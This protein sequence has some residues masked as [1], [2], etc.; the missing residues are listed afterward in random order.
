MVES[1]EKKKKIEK[2]SKERIYEMPLPNDY[3]RICGAQHFSV[4]E[5]ED[6]KKNN[7]DTIPYSVGNLERKCVQKKEF[8]VEKKKDLVKSLGEYVSSSKDEINFIQSILEPM[9]ISIN[10]KDDFEDKLAKAVFV[11]ALESFIDNLIND[12]LS[13]FQSQKKDENEIK[14][15]VP[16]HIYTSIMTIKEYMFLRKDE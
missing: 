3:C 2:K 9:K 14:V 7:W 10:H 16:I 11:K 5:L 1:P 6:C 4:E 15:F 13:V 8:K 12:S